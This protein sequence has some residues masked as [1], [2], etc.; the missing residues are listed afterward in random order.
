[1][2][3]K[4]MFSMIA[5]LTGASMITGCIGLPQNNEEDGNNDTIASVQTD[6]TE[7]PPAEEPT[8]KD[9]SIEEPTVQIAAEDGDF[10]KFLNSSVPAVK[11][12]GSEI[13]RCDI[14]MRTI[15]QLDVDNDKEKELLLDGTDGG[16]IIDIRDGGYYVLVEENDINNLYYGLDDSGEFWIV[17]GN[18]SENDEYYDFYRYEGETVAESKNVHVGRL[19]DGSLYYEIDGVSA[20]EGDVI[21]FDDTIF[22][23]WRL[24]RFNNEYLKSYAL[25]SMLKS[26]GYDS[27]EYLMKMFA[28][29]IV[30]AGGEET[31]KEMQSGMNYEKKMSKD[32]FDTVVS[33]LFSM[34]PDEFAKNNV[35]GYTG[36]FGV[37]YVADD[38]CYYAYNF[39]G[40]GEY[41]ELNNFSMDDN[42]NYIMEYNVNDGYSG[43]MIGEVTLDL[44]FTLND[45]DFTVVDVQ[46]EQVK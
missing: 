15:G 1:M 23:S 40:W 6:V 41:A 21:T 25:Y 12:D 38:D 45:I 44:Q 31:D 46:T 18:F 4:M 7:E 8:E 42:H 33:Q 9:P 10:T 11:E 2:K 35:F 36:E 26:G 39:V 28:Y 5:V 27:D 24:I 30:C 16:M 43:C 19:E 17:K 20:T 22:E 32:L 13:K 29:N 3:R 37:E 14:D 34:D